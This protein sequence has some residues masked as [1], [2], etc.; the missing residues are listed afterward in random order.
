MLVNISTGIQTQVECTHRI[1]TKGR[2]VLAHPINTEPLILQ[3]EVLLLAVTK[4]EDIQAV[5]DR[6]EDYGLSRFDGICDD[7][8]WICGLDE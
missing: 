6:H 2:N 3:G 1:T 5:V 7:L 8:S 4:A